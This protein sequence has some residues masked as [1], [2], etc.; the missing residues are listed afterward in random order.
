MSSL[1]GKA[2]SSQISAR[3]AAVKAVH[4]VMQGQSL[5]QLL[6]QLEERVIDDDGG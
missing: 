3:Y 5:N 4:Q 1:Y 2:S 6:P